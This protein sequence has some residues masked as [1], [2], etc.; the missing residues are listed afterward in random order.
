MVLP[1]G[2]ERGDQELIKLRRVE[3]GFETEKLCDVRFVPLLPGV[4][5]ERARG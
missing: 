5:Q 4:P 3:G 2:P 1:L